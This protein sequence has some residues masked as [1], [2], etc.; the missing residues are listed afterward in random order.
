VSER[1]LELAA[2]QAELQL[3]CAA[4]RRAVAVELRSIESRFESV[5][6]VASAAQRVLR[7]PAVIA[8]G[9]VV[10]LALGRMGGFRLLGRALLLLTAGR[11]LLNALRL[12]RAV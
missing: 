2:R 12:F 10:L 3:R 8:G 1:V 9:T 5:D 11:R 6:R 4:Q 7:N